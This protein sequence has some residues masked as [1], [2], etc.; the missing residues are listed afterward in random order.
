M[1][2]QLGIRKWLL[3]FIVLRFALRIQGCTQQQAVLAYNTRCAPEQKQT[4]RDR[5]TNKSRY[6]V[7]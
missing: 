5:Q 3:L 2:P 7:L 1:Q 6:V 4:A